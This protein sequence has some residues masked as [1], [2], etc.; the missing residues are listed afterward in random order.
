MV[1][2]RR[3]RGPAQAL[4][5]KT[6][7][8][9]RTAASPETR[10]VTSPVRDAAGC[11]RGCERVKRADKVREKKWGGEGGRVLPAAERAPPCAPPKLGAGRRPPSQLLL[12]I[13]VCR[14]VQVVSTTGAISSSEELLSRFAPCGLKR[15]REKQ[16]A[17]VRRHY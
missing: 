1:Q 10:L 2:P 6:V 7:Q 3:V 4:W 13:A 8:S 9:R 17:G 16:T 12:E 14:R 5:A 15:H 11:E